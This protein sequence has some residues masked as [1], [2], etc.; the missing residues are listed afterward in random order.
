MKRLLFSFTLSV[1]AL[2]AHGKV[3][4]TTLDS[5]CTLIKAFQANTEG[6]SHTDQS[7]HYQVSFPGDHFNVL[8]YNRLA[9]HAICKKFDNK[10]LLLVTQN[11]DLTKVTAVVLPRFKNGFGP[12]EL[13]FPEGYLKT[14]VYE[15]GRLVTTTS[16]RLLEFFTTNDKGGATD[17]K[18]YAYWKHYKTLAHLCHLMQ[19]EKGLIDE[20]YVKKIDKRFNEF[21]TKQSYSF[22]EQVLSEY[23]QEKIVPLYLDE[24]RE[25][26][27]YYRNED[28]KALKFIDSLCLL[29]KF[30][31]HL[32]EKAFG[33]YNTEAREKVMYRNA[34]HLSNAPISMY[35]ASSKREKSG[36]WSMIVNNNIVT[37]YIYLLEYNFQNQYK[38]VN[39]YEALVN[40]LKEKVPRQYIK[41]SPQLSNQIF[42]YALGSP[43]AIIFEYKLVEGDRRFEKDTHVSLKFTTNETHVKGLKQEGNFYKTGLD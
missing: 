26:Y 5:L 39:F 36:P 28:E 29:Y 33:N 7:G 41:T 27:E 3:P 35:Y 21:L 40:Q 34:Y 42:V 18:D 10:E 19:M 11:I 12:I 6:R 22:A 2:T 9:Y 32:N 16:P 37:D 23:K 1:F 43:V 30:K 20:E 38:T 17:R 13:W 14:E 4:Y 31:P 8:S 24:V 15:A 25:T